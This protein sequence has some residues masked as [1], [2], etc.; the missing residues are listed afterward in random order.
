MTSAV[1]MFEERPDKGAHT[2]AGAITAGFA[3][4]LF[5]FMWLWTIEVPIPPIPP[6]P[7]PPVIE[8]FT[9]AGVDGGTNQEMGG[10]SQGNTGQS[11][12]ENNDV[13]PND[14]KN[15]SNPGAI[16]NENSDADYSP[17]KP[18]PGSNESSVSNETQALL[19]KLKNKKNNTTIKIG[20]D[21]SGSPYSSGSGNGTGPG[22]GPNDGG[23]PGSGNGTGGKTYRK[24]V[25]KPDISNPTQEEG[26]VIV[27]VRV[28]KDG[29]V[30]FAE[31]QD[32]GSTTG[33][34]VLKSLAAQSAYKILFSA[35]PDGPELL[36][37]NVNINFTL[38]K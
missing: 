25:F 1:V 19:D 13:N 29:S 37:L 32:A 11:G 6:D 31:A 20:G 18:T 7:E 5:L 10:G 4:L 28:R 9:I 12:A 3:I 16:T 8:L 35:D 14:S 26:I 24:I 21:G 34:P 17:T 15:P 23:I 36:E 38:N 2:S 22:V 30:Q 27:K 33:N